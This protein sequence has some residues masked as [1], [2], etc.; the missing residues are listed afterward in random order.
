MRRLRDDAVIAEEAS[1]VW[2]ARTHIEFQPLPLSWLCQH[3]EQA[4]T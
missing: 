1:L 3:H 2:A 4:H